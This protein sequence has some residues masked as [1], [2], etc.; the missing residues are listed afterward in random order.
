MR[1]D[2]EAIAQRQ[3][4]SEK[5]RHE[6]KG[7]SRYLQ[8]KERMKRLDDHVARRHDKLTML[9]YEKGV[10]QEDYLVELEVQPSFIHFLDDLM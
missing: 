6:S 7:T 1:G 10:V 3:T 8:L 2:E 4:I 9:E 5:M